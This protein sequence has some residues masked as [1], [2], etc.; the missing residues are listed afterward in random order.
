MEILV[1]K[2]NLTNTKHIKNVSP[3]LNRHPS[4]LNICHVEPAGQT[5]HDLLLRQPFF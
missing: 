2:T 1:F 5:Q 3:D 4:F